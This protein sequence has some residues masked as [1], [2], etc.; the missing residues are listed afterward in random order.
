MRQFSSALAIALAFAVSPASAQ[1]AA[2]G[3]A[4]WGTPSVDG[5]KCCTSL[6]EV[7]TNIDRI[8]H[9][10]IRLMAERGK[11]VAE[12]GRFKANPAAVSVPARVEQIILKVREIARE[13]GLSDVVAEKT[14]RAMIAAFEDY[15]REEWVRRGDTGLQ[16]QK[17]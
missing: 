6:A 2:A 5:G 9:E 4:Y 12:A 13:N 16:P 11:Y 17:Q 7:R 10:M 1:D 15:E 14:Y 8:D 3:K